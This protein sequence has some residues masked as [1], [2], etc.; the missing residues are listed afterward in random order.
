[1]KARIDKY[2]GRIIWVLQVWRLETISRSIEC[3]PKGKSAMS[4]VKEMHEL[5]GGGKEQQNSN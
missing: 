3:A 4:K 2:G 1:M 5:Q